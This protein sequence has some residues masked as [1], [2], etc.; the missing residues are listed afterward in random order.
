MGV[1]GY[2]AIAA[3]VVGL[4]MTFVGDSVAERRRTAAR[5]VAI[6]RRL[7]LIM[8]HLGIDDPEPHLAEVI[9]NLEQ[10]RKIPAIKAYR[11]GTGTGLAE[12][13]KAVERLARERGLDIR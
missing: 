2:L 13:K 10:G 7:R 6:D 12:A 11:D 8:D 1:W 4:A 9:A 5:L 3:A